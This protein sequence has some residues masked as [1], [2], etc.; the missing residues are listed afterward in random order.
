M[1]DRFDT[2]R[3]AIAYCSALHQD[4]E[5]A[6]AAVKAHADGWGIATALAS[7]LLTAVEG[8]MPDTDPAAFLRG[9]RLQIATQTEGGPGAPAD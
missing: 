8:A 9:D 2:M 5:A 6:V 3:D 1:P 7:L 4:D